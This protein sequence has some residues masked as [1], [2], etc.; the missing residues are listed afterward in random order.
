[1]HVPF[2]KPSI[3]SEELEAVKKVLDSGWLTTGPVASEFERQF[4]AFIGCKHA[5]AVNSATA[6]LQL[7]VDALGLQPGDEVLVPAYTFTATAAVVIHAGARPVLC[8]SLK[9]GFNIC[10]EDAE[11]RITP[12]TRAIIPVHVA[13]QP[14][15]LDRIH[16]LA[17]KHGLH[18]IEDAAHALPSSYKGARIGAI[19][20][21]TAFSF[22]ATKTLSTG[23][24]GMLTTNN[25]AFVERAMQMRLHGISGDAWRRYSNKGNWFY[26]VRH[27]GYKLN[28]CDVLAAI[29]CVQLTKTQSMWE[30][31]CRIAKIYSEI[32]SRFEELQVPPAVEADTEHSWHLYILRVRPELLTS[33]RD[34][35]IQE[36]KQRGIGASV[37]FIPLH[38]HSLYTEKYG[39]QRGDFPN[40]E[41][42]YFRCLSLPIFPD[43]TEEEIER[44]TGSVQSILEQKRIP[45]AAA[46]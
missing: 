35:F 37:H 41:D 21:L 12:K 22:Y 14:C 2:H 16:V 43:M 44:V 46:S 5:L 31:R 6:A 36:L 28:M 19:S 42:S 11:R 10:P 40:A 26:D 4:A 30:R 39:Y 23:E 3:G 32:L 8:D 45:L 24:G 27:A 34:E 15:D 33:G 1:M 17:A 25:S 29:G 18:V 13:G 9:D 38:L 7:A 20:E